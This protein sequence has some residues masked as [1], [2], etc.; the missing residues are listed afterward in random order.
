MN[1]KIFTLI[2]FV[3]LFTAGGKALAHVSNM[4]PSFV[5][6]KF[7]QP[8]E[9]IKVF[10]QAVDRGELI[11]FEQVIDR[12]MIVPVEVEYVYQ[13][14][15]AIPR[16]SVYA[17]LKQPIPVR[18]ADGCEVHAVS[19]VLDNAGSIVESVVHIWSGDQ[20]SAD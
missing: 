7:D 11:V 3:M 16:L 10:L 4:P 14:D 12:S 5:E 8:R 18:D 15:S 13:L 20:R 1:I 17:E 9:V 19:A 6:H 2:A